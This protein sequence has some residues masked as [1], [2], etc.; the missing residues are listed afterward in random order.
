MKRRTPI[1]AIRRFLQNG[2]SG[3]LLLI[4]TAA[5]AMVVA[6]SP[7]SDV[8]FDT[9][10]TYFAG[11]DLRTW[12]NDA[13]MTLFFLLVGLEIKRELLD[14]ELSSPARRRLPV[15]AA[16]A[17]MAVPALIFIAINRG[18]PD[19]LHGWAIPAATDIAFALGI[20][21]LLGSRVP[22]SI[23]LF[24]TAVAIIDDL[25]AIVIIAVAYTEQINFLALGAAAAM[26]ALLGGLNRAKIDAVWPYLLIGAGV[27]FA[28]LQSGVHATLAGVAVAATIPLRVT[29]GR[30]EDATSPLLRL[31]HALSPI[32]AFIVVPLFAFANAG[33]DLRGIAPAALIAPLPLGIAVALVVGKQVGVFGAVW[34]MVRLDLAD[35]P[36]DATWRQV[37]GAALLC[38]I[39]FTMSLFIAN[40]AF[41]DAA[42]IDAA[43][44][45]IVAGSLIAALAGTAV[46]LTGRR[47]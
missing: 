34:A 19:A 13:P 26:L 24:V 28:V 17:G 14:G 22:A 11:H 9:L 5:L 32:V 25:G 31:E 23:K 27:W 3:G 8:Y 37:W 29:R 44:L 46:L 10:G 16:L 18:D 39:G 2:S 15:V 35:C 21:A 33:L 6:N 12:I 7:V 47:R 20:L 30:P 41:S 38:G 42:Q 36:A 40:L 4:A 45:G 1:T 43:K